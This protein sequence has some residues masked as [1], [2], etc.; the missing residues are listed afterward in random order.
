MKMI[1]GILITLM[2]IN[3]FILGLLFMYFIV[4]FT[5]LKLFT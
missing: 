2:T 3:A 1:R 4:G 5:F